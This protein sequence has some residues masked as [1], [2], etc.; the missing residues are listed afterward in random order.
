MQITPSGIQKLRH[1]FV[2]TQLHEVPC[3]K[4]AQCPTR[5]C[6]KT[7][8][9]FLSGPLGAETGDGKANPPRCLK[10]YVFSWK[11]ARGIEQDS[12]EDGFRRSRPRTANCSFRLSKHPQAH[13]TDLDEAIACILSATQLSGHQCLALEERHAVPLYR[14]SALGLF[15]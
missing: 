15:L 1:A 11:L 8:C 2:S 6:S 14:N 9:S 4:L 10:V 3:L 12:E 13:K 5:M 7:C